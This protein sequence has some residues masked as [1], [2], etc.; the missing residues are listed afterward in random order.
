MPRKTE[1]DDMI[2]AAARSF[3]EAAARCR[4]KRGAR[5]GTPRGGP[6]FNEA[7]ARC[8]GKPFVRSRRYWADWAPLQ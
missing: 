1:E 3:N 7:A 6:R 5:R 2:R 8:R 4:G